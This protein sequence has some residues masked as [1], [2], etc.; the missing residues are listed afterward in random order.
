MT[1]TKSTIGRRLKF[2]RETRNLTQQGLAGQ[3]ERGLNYTLIGK[4]ERG[5]TMP[6]VQTLV[7][8]AAALKVRISYFLG[9]D[10]EDGTILA[11]GRNPRKNYIVR[12]LKAMDSDDLE[13]LCE[14][15]R[16]LERHNRFHRR[17]YPASQRAGLA[18][19]ADRKPGRGR[20]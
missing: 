10:P 16:L 1:I 14:V 5:E 9:E 11:L 15:I 3:I 13:L 17:E 2:L 6:S 19:A 12:K 20:R 4:I 18:R 7:R 8:L